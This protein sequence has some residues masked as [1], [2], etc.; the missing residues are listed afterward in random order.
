MADSEVRV[1]LARRKDPPFGHVDVSE[2]GRNTLGKIVVEIFDGAKK[3]N[4]VKFHPDDAGDDES[5]LVAQLKGFDNYFQPRARWSLER[6]VK[7][8]R[9]TGIPEILDAGEISEGGWTFYAIR[10]TDKKRDLVAIR[11]KSPTYGLDMHSKFVTRVIGNELRPVEEP[12]LSFDHSADLLVSKKKV[13]VLNPGLAEKLLV[14][15]EAVKERAPDLARRFGEGVAAKFPSATVAAIERVCSHNA[16]LGRRVEHL[17]READLS[18]VTAASIREGLPSAGLP[19]DA[20]GKTPSP[21]RVSTD[22]HARKLIEIAADLYYQPRHE[23]QP[24]K[25]SSYRKLARSRSTALRSV[26][27]PKP[28]RMAQSGSAGP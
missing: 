22:D 2:A 14:D 24:R 11:A 10:F 3:S 5:V 23:D 18:R 13:Y 6:T 17:N 9:S 28:D 26:G 8:I 16:P 15:A 19:S 1:M 27:V 12:L 20:F 7:E 4:E 25:V 21:I